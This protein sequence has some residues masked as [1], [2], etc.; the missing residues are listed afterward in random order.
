MV[1]VGACC[2]EQDQLLRAPASALGCTARGRW[3]RQS[4][5]CPR[6]LD[7]GDNDAGRSIGLM[8]Q[9]SERHQHQP[10]LQQ[11]RYS[12]S[13]QVIFPP[14]ANISPQYGGVG[15]AGRWGGG[16]RRANSSEFSELGSCR[17]NPALGFHWKPGMMRGA[18]S[19]VSGWRGHRP[20]SSHVTENGS[21]RPEAAR[22][23]VW[24]ARGEGTNSTGGDTATRASSRP[25]R[26]CAQG[27]EEPPPRA[28]GLKPASPNCFG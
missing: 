18:S 20:N 24:A 3:D 4:R 14:V 7:G 17:L 11:L 9:P 6:L 13:W 25:T 23:A 5:G 16:E 1:V 8:A 22:C 27:T 15:G 28:Q 26:S 12:T 21:E 19:S 2:A 10:G